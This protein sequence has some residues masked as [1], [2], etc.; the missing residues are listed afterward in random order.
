MIEFNSPPSR[1]RGNSRRISPFRSFSSFRVFFASFYSCFGD[2][3]FVDFS[4]FFASFVW[5]SLLSCRRRKNR[6]KM[7]YQNLIWSKNM[8]RSPKMK[9]WTVIWSD[10]NCHDFY[11]FACVSCSF[12]HFLCCERKWARGNS[13]MLSRWPNYPP[14]RSRETSSRSRREVNCDLWLYC[15]LYYFLNII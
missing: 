10:K 5:M 13:L 2:C 6:R 9:L 3:L 8:R 4:Y 15:V 11:I 1:S 12:A 7:S 14:V